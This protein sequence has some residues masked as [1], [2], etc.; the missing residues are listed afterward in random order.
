[1]TGAVATPRSE[2]PGD[3]ALDLTLRMVLH[4]F[5]RAFKQEATA[6]W[7][8]PGAVVL[9]GASPGGPA[10]TVVARW[11]AKIA[12]RARD[13]GR[14]HV[15]SVHHPDDDLV[16]DVA[17]RQ[18]DTIPAWAAGIPELASSLLGAPSPAREFGGAS[19]LVYMDVPDESGILAGPALHTALALALVD[20][21]GLPNEPAGL[22]AALGGHGETAAAH[23]A[24][25]SGRHGHAM[26]ITAGS[27]AGDHI[28]FDPT[29]A[30]L[31]LVLMSARP[32][33]AATPRDGW[34]PDPSDDARVGAAVKAIAV[35][36]WPALGNLFTTAHRA[37]VG[38]REPV[39]ADLLVDSA[40]A[41]GALGGR[42]TSS[43]T[44][45]ALV[46]AQSLRDLRAAAAH[47]FAQR[48][49][50]APRLLTTGLLPPAVARPESLL[51]G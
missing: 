50:S 45:F 13:D 47:A 39:D 1:M 3:D 51:E 27:A 49:R 10:L 19:L 9:L 38:L 36:D 18:G 12:G 31:R 26:L 6:G 8:A 41:T 32:D 21:A 7:S 16:L 25:L 15:S 24:S 14:L 20:V 48:G 34:A 23:A 5:G 42:A 4:L 44:A 35:Q 22:L 43:T 11:G 40:L 2:V 30:G 17:T 46:P 33:R 29:A 37:G 28:A